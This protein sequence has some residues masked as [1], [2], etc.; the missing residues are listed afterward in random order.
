M[1]E[2]ETPKSLSHQTGPPCPAKVQREVSQGGGGSYRRRMLVDVGTVR[3]VDED[4]VHVLDVC[5]DDGQVGQGRQR[6]GLILILR[7]TK[8]TSA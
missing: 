8:N 7:R 6:P 2:S 1:G 4:G 5:D 3:Q